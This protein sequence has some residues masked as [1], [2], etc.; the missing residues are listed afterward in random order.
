MLSL[1]LLLLVG[2]GITFISMQNTAEVS[3]TFL[4]YTIPNLPLY[5][6]IIASIL[7]GVVLAYCISFVN[8]VSTF[9]VIRRQ[10]KTIGQEK[11]EVVALTKRVHQLELENV[12]LQT[13][14]DTK[15]VDSNAL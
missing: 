1:I 15:E 10:H 12:G 4:H 14:N 11:K 9:M 3:L 8:S 5:S 6:V 13:E 2:A 7:I